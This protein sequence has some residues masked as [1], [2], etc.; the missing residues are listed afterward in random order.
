MLELLQPGSIV[1]TILAQDRRVL[2][3]GAPG[4]GKSTL[5]TQLAQALVANARQCRC[6]SADPGSPVLG[7]PGAVT[8]GEWQTDHWQVSTME[9]LCTLDAGRFRLPLVS[10]VRR[11]LSQ[12][13]EGVVLIDG[14]GVVR[15][16]VGREL[17]EGLLEVTA[18]EVILVV[19]PTVSAPPLLDELRMQSRPRVF[20]VPAAEEAVRP[21]KR[22]RARRRT[23]Q[24]DTYLAG[25]TTQDFDLSQ[26]NIIGTPPPREQPQ[27][28]T[29]RQ[30]ALLEAQHTVAMGE[31][32]RLQGD[33]LTVSLPCQVSSADTLLIRNTQRTA[34]GVLETA[35]PWAAERLEYLPPAAV[36]PAIQTSNGP[37]LVGRVGAVD[38]A[39]INGVFGDPLLHVRFQHQQRSLLFDLGSGERLSARVA[40]QTSDVFISH[41]HLDHISGFVSLM[42]SR[43][44]EFPPCRVYGPPGLAVHIAGFLQGALWD[45]VALNAPRF[46][47][48]E[49]D[50][51]SL[52]HFALRATQPRPQLRETRAVQE[53]II[54]AEAGFQIRAVLLDHTGTPVV[55]YALEPDR[56]I[57]V[58][59]DRLRARGLEP[60]PWL[61]ELKQR[62]AGG[63]E[64]VRIQLPDGSE[65]T[66]QTL[67]SELL[68]ISP[69]KKLVYATDL[70]DTPDNRERL[71]DL[72]RHAHTFFCEAPFIT[73]E[74]EHALRNGHLTT[75]ASAEIANAAGVA[76]LVPFHLSRRYQ[77]DP[78]QIY[79]EIKEICPRVV[80]PAP[81]LF[82]M[83]ADATL[84]LE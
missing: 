71:I 5:A 19:T 15:G 51:K 22:V 78:Q 53:G 11:V 56:Q 59:K 4:V 80:V 60:G 43:I 24:W 65:E 38:V 35:E 83:P 66:V 31:V 36:L 34:D 13:L 73:A 33:C 39:L 26:L 49:F 37:R 41:A 77:S 63:D 62:V 57:N 74:A 32:Q 25:G 42:R 9:A 8:L 1:E 21:G 54:R 3:V 58:R 16:V 55:A 29:G 82:A 79:D 44:G 69:G 84:E 12:P 72:A 10:A 2:L 67:A 75:R 61:S 70:A 23:A 45:R 68:L 46:E 40:H 17:L 20:V 28:W 7:V 48:I 27:A 50:G 76:R 47:V 64:T 52:R 18:A 30:V 14:P 6:V 81:H